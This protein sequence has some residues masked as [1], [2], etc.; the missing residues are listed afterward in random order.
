VETAEFDPRDSGQV[1]AY[2]LSALIGRWPS[3]SSVVALEYV[4]AATS[5]WVWFVE[6]HGEHLPSS[7]QG[8]CALRI[9]RSGQEEE[10]ESE[11][12]LGESLALLG[13]PVAEGLWSGV[14]AGSHPALLQRRLPGRMAMEAVKSVRIR[15]VVGRLARLQS[16]LHQLPTN[17]VRLHTMSAADYVE[18]DLGRRRRAVSAVDPT[19]TWEWLCRSAPLM[20]TDDVVVCHGDFHPLNVLVDRDGSMGVIDWTDACIADRHHDVGRTASL[21]GLAYVLAGS[22]PERVALRGIRK[23]LVS[24]HLDAYETS[25]GIQLDRR[26]LAWWQAVHAFRG[27]LQ[28]CE[29]A[30][31]T[32]ED[33]GST[34]VAAIPASTRDTLL[35]HCVDFRKSS[36]R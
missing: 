10:T 15:S 26:R 29:L 32:V 16:R 30:E 7:L 3:V 9:F 27:W 12:R 1:V 23:R 18:S 25:A 28:L 24:W 11:V 6:I 19:G 2:L 4:S 5:T 14:L 22:A 33:R 21:Y 13:F 31:G 20:A 34:T 8:P 17:L 35:E 36:G